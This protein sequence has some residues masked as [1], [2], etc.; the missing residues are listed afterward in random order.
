MR[1]LA[2]SAQIPYP[3]TSGK[4]M[5][6]YSL[7]TGLARQHRVRLLCLARGKQEVEEAAALARVVPFE[8]APL[9]V[10]SIPRR[11]AALLFSARPDL[12]VRT[13]SARFRQLLAG[14]LAG[15]PPNLLL[16]E[17]LEMAAYGLRIQ[18]RRRDLP[19]VLDEHNAEYLL[20][21]RAWTI[22]RE[23]GRSR[24]AALYSLIQAGR[25]ARFEARACLAA[26]RVIAVSA[27]DRQ[28]LLKIAPRAKIDLVPNGIDTDHYAPRPLP[29]SPQPTL[30]FTGQMDYRPNT[31]A[32][33]WFY[34]EIWP[35]IRAEAP[36]ARLYIVGRDPTPAVLALDGQHG[37]EVT[38]AVVDDRPWIG[39]ADVYILP[40]R[41]GGG[42][43]LKLLQALA[44][45]RAVVSTPLGA[46]GVEGLV[47]GEHLALAAS[48][49][50]FA[51]RT[52]QLLRDPLDRARMGRAGRE[53]VVA[54]YD[55]QVLLPHFEEIL[56]QAAGRGD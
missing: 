46:E 19:L 24:L 3:P 15:D 28:A 29:P 55:W 35:R 33:H 25:L 34:A 18:K 45:E 44:M 36:D 8:T 6:D 5:R 48:A 1:I 23:E 11:L 4:A 38:G 7:L 17:G 49:E 10:H 56:L 50:A 41:F 39:Q 12:V 47:D 31:D 42:I 20:Q 40:M 37:V 32:V 26:S 13:E 52:V 16:I 53:L 30:V 43:R 21:Q 54:R 22:S 2:L 14:E 9:P 51:A 27:A